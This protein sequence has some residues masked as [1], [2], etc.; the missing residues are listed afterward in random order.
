MALTMLRCGSDSV[1]NI[2][3]IIVDEDVELI[4]DAMKFGRN[5]YENIRKFLQ[6]Q[7]ST[8]INMITY[9]AVGTL[10]YKDW[11]IQPAILL[12]MNFVTDTFAATIMAI[13]LPGKN[14]D[15][16]K[17]TMPFDKKENRLFN[18][19]MVFTVVT[20]I[21]YQ[22]IILIVLFYNGK[23]WF[24][25]EYNF[26]TPQQFFIPGTSVRTPDG[27]MAPTIKCYCYTYTLQT[28]FSMQMFN[29]FNCM[30]TWESKGPFLKIL[31]IF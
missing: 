26:S 13:Q 15:I 5:I 17:R 22:Q 24:L 14:S 2:S 27:L 30:S 25:K 3:D 11:P 18:S 20:S 16:L 6:F 29:L 21:I 7:K 31:G 8:A 19:K 9:V 28:F 10:L 4:V 12:F 1:K 23:T